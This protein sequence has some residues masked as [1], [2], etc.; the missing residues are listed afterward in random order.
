MAVV[1]CTKHYK[2]SNKYKVFIN[3]WDIHESSA[4][5]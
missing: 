2:L 5:H 4:M 1:Q 3:A